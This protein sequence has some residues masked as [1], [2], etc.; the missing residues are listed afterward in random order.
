VCKCPQRLEAT[1]SHGAG[2]TSS[3]ELPSVGTETKLW[4]SESGEMLFSVEPS[5]Q[6]LL[7]LTLSM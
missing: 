6:P 5:L 3:C 7:F 2:V 1:G 4:S